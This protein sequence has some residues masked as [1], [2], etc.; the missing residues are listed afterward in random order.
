MYDDGMTMIGRGHVPPRYAL[1]S[2]TTPIY[3]LYGGLDTLADISSSKKDFPKNPIEF[4]KVDHYEHLDF[5]WANDIHHVVMP[6]IIPLLLT[7]LEKFNSQPESLSHSNILF[8][9]SDSFKESSSEMNISHSVLSNG[10]LEK[11][12]ISSTSLQKKLHT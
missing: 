1:S 9:P 3:A 2:I 6:L 7:R 8:N 11:F 12:L 10:S 4:I 5:L